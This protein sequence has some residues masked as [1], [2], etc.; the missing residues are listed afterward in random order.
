L[1][2]QFDA[3][4]TTFTNAYVARSG[5]PDVAFE[6]NVPPAPAMKFVLYD[7][8][9]VAGVSPAQEQPQSNNETNTVVPVPPA[10]PASLLPL[11]ALSFVSFQG[12]IF[13]NNTCDT[14]VELE[15]GVERFGG[16]TLFE[17]SIF[18]LNDANTALIR[19][20]DN[21][22]SLAR[23]VIDAAVSGTGTT[24]SSLALSSAPFALKQCQ[25]DNNTAFDLIVL[26]NREADVTLKACDFLHNEGSLVSI[27][28][29][30]STIM[31]TITFSGNGPRRLLNTNTNVNTGLPGDMIDIT[32][33]QLTM[34]NLVMDNNDYYTNV[35]GTD[36][37]LNVR[38]SI[39][40]L[41]A[42][43]GGSNDIQGTNAKCQDC[44]FTNNL[45]KGEI[46]AIASYQNVDFT[47]S[48]F[49]NNTAQDSIVRNIFGEVFTCTNCWF[50]DN[51]Q[52]SPSG[53]GNEAV[54]FL[55]GAGRLDKCV[56]RNNAFQRGVAMIGR[57]ESFSVVSD[58]CFMDNTF[59][60]AAIIQYGYTPKDQVL[61]A[62]TSSNY[63]G[64]NTLANAA[65]SPC[66]G[67][68]YGPIGSGTN[69]TCAPMTGAACDVA[70]PAMEP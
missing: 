30:T 7:T 11:V 51:T 34:K 57:T 1:G 33:A 10:Q 49:T 56:F 18:R 64:N 60:G 29:A 24:A 69:G 47:G 68:L 40:A 52:L 5:S 27:A 14:L 26:I 54:V 2:F 4:D 16:G 42:V 9:V 55:L 38:A 3:I 59:S 20:Y 37:I 21:P 36:S 45:V 41:A 6:T 15:V 25:F 35:I 32:S 50:E 23:Q 67:V 66:D 12:G 62:V 65:V 46:V 39:S 19:M 61:L 70:L 44:I 63:A 22:M 31:D 58:S 43:G 53:L 48:K 28:N 13:E 8:R 17:N